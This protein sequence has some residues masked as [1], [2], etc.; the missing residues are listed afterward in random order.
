MYA[1]VV[2]VGQREG[3][4]EREEQGAVGERKVI[5][6]VLRSST[7]LITGGPLKIL[8]KCLIRFGNL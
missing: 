6:A 5:D 8:H 2:R 7:S 1:H 4:S 3:E